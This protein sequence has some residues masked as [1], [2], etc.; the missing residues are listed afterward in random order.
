MNMSE[1]MPYYRLYQERP[2]STEALLHLPELDPVPTVPEAVE[3][4]ARPLF[5]QWLGTKAIERPDSNLLFFVD[6]VAASA[7]HGAAVA[8]Q[9][10]ARPEDKP[11]QLAA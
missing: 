7:E 3:R 1:Q 11:E 4:P 6:Q 10:A 8:A 9:L 2:S 5:A